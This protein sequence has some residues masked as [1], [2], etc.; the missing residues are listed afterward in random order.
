VPGQQATF[1]YEP[2]AY[3]FTGSPRRPT[4]KQINAASHVVRSYLILYRKPIY[5]VAA[6]VLRVTNVAKDSNAARNGLKTGDYLAEYDGQELDS[7][8]DLRAAIQAAASK[9]EVTAV[10]YRG[11]KRLELTLE[12]G[13][14]GVNLSMR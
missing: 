4:E 7:V 9:K 13:R 5:V 8:D 3:D 12:S 14:M 2:Q 11:A 1:R 10:V 6:P